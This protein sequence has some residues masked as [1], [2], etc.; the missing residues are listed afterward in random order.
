MYA[1][2]LIVDDSKV[3]R[4]MIKK[5]IAEISPETTVFEAAD[6]NEALSSLKENDIKA[7]IVDFHMPGIDGLEL[8]EKIRAIDADLPVTLLTANIQNEIK[9]R[10]DELDAGYLSKPANKDDLAD[11]LA[12]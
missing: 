8:T 11:F 10:A 5:I 2:V 3:S 1:S 12:G 4:M 7:A 9:K 6:G